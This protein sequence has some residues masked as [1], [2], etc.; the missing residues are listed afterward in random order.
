MHRILS[1]IFTAGHYHTKNLLIIR[2]IAETA[3]YK[4]PSHSGSSPMLTN[5]REYDLASI[6]LALHP[7]IPIIP[8]GILILIY[9]QFR[10]IYYPLLHIRLF[11]N[12]HLTISLTLSIFRFRFARCK[13]VMGHPYQHLLSVG[14]VSFHYQKKVIG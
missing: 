6:R 14:I 13:I 12:H 7:Q 2:Y 11:L 3:V 9:L 1:H 8:L 5:K 4:N 10:N